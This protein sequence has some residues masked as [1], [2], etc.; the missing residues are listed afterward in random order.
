MSL[1]FKAL[2]LRTLIHRLHEPIRFATPAGPR[3]RGVLG[4]AVLD[5]GS[6]P[7][8]TTPAA[9]QFGN[10]EAGLACQLGDFALHLRALLVLSLGKSRL[11]G[12]PRLDQLL[13]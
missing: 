10:L 4:V 8:S 12:I 5:T 3:L 2:Q 11:D 7:L 13:V 9:E 1:H 6:R